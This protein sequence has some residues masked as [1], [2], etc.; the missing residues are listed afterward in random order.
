MVS[1]HP[2]KKEAALI[3][4][5][6][7]GDDYMQKAASY[8]NALNPAQDGDYQ[9]DGLLYCGKCKTARE[10][11]VKVPGSD[12]PWTVRCM[13]KC[14]SE[15]WKQERAQTQ[16]KAVE[17][18]RK[19]A[20]PYEKYRDMT[21]SKSD[22]KL[23]F[24]ERYVAKW[25]EM[26]KSNIGLYLHGNTGGGKT[27]I[28]AA[29][30]NALV[31]MGEWVYMHNMAAMS[32]MLRDTFNGGHGELMHKVTMARMFIIDDFGTE[33]TTDYALQ[34]TYEL[35]EARTESGRPLIVTSN[36]SPGVLTGATDIRLQRLYSRLTALHPIAVN[37]ADR[38]KVATKERYKELN[39]M[40][41]ITGE[42]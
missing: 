24:A 36:L 8:V 26:F 11:V 18:N 29:I 20:L 5:F 3:N 42:K 7:S 25:D 28:A 35:I 17:E 32:N 30:A 4:R 13:C 14:Q 21:F 22:V 41:G 38:R 40:L 12:K 15:S 39:D 6:N 34:N 16:Q 2:K 37:G 33:C 27:Y 9:Q 31:D 1:C 23:N 19:Q 10:C